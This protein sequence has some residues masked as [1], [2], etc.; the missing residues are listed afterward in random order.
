MTWRPSVL[1]RGFR[2][3]RWLRVGFIFTSLWH[4][5]HSMSA[6]F[7]RHLCSILR[8]F[9]SGL[10]PFRRHFGCIVAPFQLHFSVIFAPLWLHLDSAWAQ[11]WLRLSSLW[12]QVMH[13]CLLQDHPTFACL[14]H[15]GAGQV[16][17]LGQIRIGR[18]APFWCKLASFLLH[19]AASWLHFAQL[20]RNF[21]SIPGPL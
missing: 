14:L 2:R 17:R 15:F 21:S 10:A 19:L 5:L 9:S 11:F 7:C 18:L 3:R 16:G 1:L 13:K 20:L 6:T 12:V 4:S 8:H